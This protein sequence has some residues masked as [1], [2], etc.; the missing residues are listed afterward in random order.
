MTTICL[1]AVILS[2]GEAGVEESLYISKIE[3]SIRFFTETW[4]C[5]HLIR[6]F[7]PPSPGGEAVARNVTDEGNSAHNIAKDIMN[8][9]RS[10]D[11]KPFCVFLVHLSTSARVAIMADTSRGLVMWAFMPA[12]CSRWIS[13]AKALAVM[14][15]T[16]MDDSDGSSRLRISRVAV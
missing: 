9:F 5:E 2:G 15:I 11:R 4:E 1:N 13:S 14:A 3:N 16:G 12:S 6:S 10:I 8:G 7:G